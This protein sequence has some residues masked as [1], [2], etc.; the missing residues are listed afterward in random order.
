M[1]PFREQVQNEQ[2]ASWA[3][4]NRRLQDEIPFQWHHHT[5]YELTLTMNSRGQRFVGDHVGN[6]GDMDLVMLGP[7]LPHTW[8]SNSK[9]DDR[10]DHVALVLKFSPEWAND[11]TQRFVEFSSLRPMLGRSRRGIKFSAGA[12]QQSQNEIQELFEAP[13]QERFLILMR[14]LSRLARDEAAEELASPYATE[15]VQKVSAQTDDRLERVLAF[16]HENYSN[17]TRL[18]EVAD[19]AALSI[20][21]VHRLF[22]RHMRVSF[23]DYVARLRV[24]EA[25][26]LLINTKMPIAR[27]AEDVGYS[28][29]AN[30]NRQ[31]KA[32][33]N[34]T[35]SQ[36]RA[37]MGQS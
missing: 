2:G 12:T 3:M 34:M 24:G 20:S 16:V 9:Y 21:G 4:L 33:K 14:V 27:I 35:P 5:E 31:F 11:L 17:Q 25:C 6:Y 26:A 29:L 19:V 7:N 37:I 10:N 23:S 8:A 30:F 22:K 18:E 28:A 13:P 15:L 32:Q 36:F 1:K